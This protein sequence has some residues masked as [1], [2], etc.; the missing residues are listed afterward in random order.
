MAVLVNFRGGAEDQPALFAVH[1]GKLLGEE[2][3]LPRSFFVEAPDSVG[4]LL[5][6]AQLLCRNFIFGEKLVQRDA[7]RARQFFQCLDGWNGAAIFQAREVTAKQPGAFLDIALREVLGFAEPLKPFADDHCE[8]L[9]YSAVPT[10]LLLKQ[11]RSERSNPGIRRSAPFRID[12]FSKANWLFPPA[13][14][15]W[16]ISAM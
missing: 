12:T 11:D 2:A 9:Q 7:Q 3:Q 5:R 16:K 4:L 15:S 1:A 6:D 14:V 13:S 8:S 10:Q